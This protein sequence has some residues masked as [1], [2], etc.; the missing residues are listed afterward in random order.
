[1]KQIL[2]ALDLSDINDHIIQYGL[3]L[4]QKLNL[5]KVHFVHSIKTFDIDE[6][7]RELLG[8]KDLKSI[9]VKNIKQRIAK[10]F[11]DE[12][13]YSLVVLQN[14][15]TEY[16]LTK[17][18]DEQGIRTVVMGFKEKDSGTGAMAQK[19]I[20]IFKG[21][22]ILVPAT[23]KF[24]WDRILV[25]TDLS[26]PFQLIVNKLDAIEKFE[27]AP[28]IRVLKSFNIPSQFFPYIDI[29]DSEAIDQTNKYVNKQ[30]LDIKKKYK[31]NHSYAFTSVYQSDKSIV[32]IIE[33]ESKKFNADLVLMTAKGASKISTIFIGSTINELI[34][35][36]PFAT[37]LILK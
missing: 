29:D 15:S 24:S 2:I 6:G 25:P 14:E 35:S 16:S 8:Q 3:F 10:Y 34:N 19:L 11:T 31:L 4:R 36:N 28:Q 1:M 21:D 12:D 30:F 33:K 5:D 37:L 27:P 23:A 20:R 26:A 9:I 32:E 22:V 18:A 17:Y 7:L 13:A